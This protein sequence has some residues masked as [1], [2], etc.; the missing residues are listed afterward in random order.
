MPHVPVT[1]TKMRFVGSN[2]QVYNDN[3]HWRL[4]GHI[5]MQGTS[6]QISIATIVKETSNYDFILPSK[7]DRA[8]L[9]FFG[10]QNDCS[11]MLYLKS[12]HFFEKFG[13][14]LPGCALPDCRIRS[15]DLTALLRNKSC[16]RLGSR[17]NRSI[18]RCWFLL[19]Y[20][21]WTL[22][23]HMAVGRILFRGPIVVF[24]GLAEKFF[25]G[26]K[27]GEISFY[28]LKT[29][30]TF[31]PKK[32]DRKTRFQISEGPRPPALPLSFDANDQCSL[33]E[34]FTLSK[35]FFRAHATA[36]PYRHNQWSVLSVKRAMRY[37]YDVEFGMMQV[38][39]NEISQRKWS[40]SIAQLRTLEGTLPMTMHKLDS[41]PVWWH[42]YGQLARIWTSRRLYK[43][44]QMDHEN[45]PQQI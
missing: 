29:K 34:N 7:Q 25:S 40:G 19:I 4:S 30:K 15:K 36:Q 20:S 11:L 12:E 9:I 22:I 24:P 43:I 14:E 2:S 23:I 6:L 10:G 42:D 31:L 3:S 8:Q 5:Q 38:R 32:I 33:W 27:S 45:S 16:K 1:I 17:L 21:R 18:K 41:Q 28:P 37:I 44:E 39:K 13:G 35:C 26:G